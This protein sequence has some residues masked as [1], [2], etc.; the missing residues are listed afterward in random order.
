MEELPQQTIELTR[1]QFTVVP[2]QHAYRFLNHTRYRESG[3][4][5]WEIFNGAIREVND[6][7]TRT[8]DHLR[9]L[10]VLPARFSY[11]GVNLNSRER[12]LIV[13]ISEVVQGYNFPDEGA[14]VPSGKFFATTTSYILDYDGFVRC[15]VQTSSEHE[16]IYPSSED[17]DRQVDLVINTIVDRIQSGRFSAERVGVVH[18]DETFATSAV[19]RVEDQKETQAI[20]RF[21]LDLHERGRVPIIEYVKGA[22]LRWIGERLYDNGAIDAGESFYSISHQVVQ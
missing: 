9:E 5:I 13:N 19:L 14:L 4:G 22:V 3:Y 1:E 8:K 6:L 16:E 10:S 18:G 11:T 15:V 21:V 2:P 12:V 7:M 17:L 20:K